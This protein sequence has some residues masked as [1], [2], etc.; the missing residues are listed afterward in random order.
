MDQITSELSY[1]QKYEKRIDVKGFAPLLMRPLR[2]T[3]EAVN[4]ELYL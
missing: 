1:P 4:S 2:I 3:D